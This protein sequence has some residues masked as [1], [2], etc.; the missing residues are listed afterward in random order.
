MSVR[1]LTHLEGRVER[2]VGGRLAAL[3]R[4]Q[5]LLEFPREGPVIRKLRSGGYRL[6]SRKIDPK[7]G[8]R[9]NLGT[10]KTRGAAEKH[11]RAVQFFKHHG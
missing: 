3:I 1:N 2:G 6:Y 8:R 9:R 11:E 10:F 5:I 4:A 7:S